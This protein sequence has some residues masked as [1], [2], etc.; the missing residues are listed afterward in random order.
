MS[1]VTSWGIGL[2]MPAILCAPL[3]TP[4]RQIPTEG[5]AQGVRLQR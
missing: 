5:Y 2:I 3:Y 4:G 1:S